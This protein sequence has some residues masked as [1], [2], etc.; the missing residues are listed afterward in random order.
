MIEFLIGNWD[1][2]SLVVTNVLALIAKS[3][4]KRF[5]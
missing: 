3:P 5:Q 4:L 1:V 2:V